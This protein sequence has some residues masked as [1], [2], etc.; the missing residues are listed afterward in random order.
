MSTIAA[1]IAAATGTAS[2]RARR[3]VNV[4][5]LRVVSAAAISRTRARSS[6]GA[7][8][9][10]PRSSAT[11][12]RCDM[13]SL[14][15]FRERPVEA[16]RAV[17]GRDPEHA[18]GRSCIEVEQDAECDDLALAGRERSESGL[19]VGR[20]PFDEALLDPVLLARRAVPAACAG[21]R[22]ESGRAPPSARPGRARCGPSRGWDRSGA[23]AAAPVRTSHRRGRRRRRGRR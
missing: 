9:R 11:R 19:E 3:H 10:A 15:E 14:L 6:G 21:A 13:E 2:T 20:E 5:R 16:R 18:G 22:S 1:P 12:S 4:G 7:P 23:R 8:M 17:R